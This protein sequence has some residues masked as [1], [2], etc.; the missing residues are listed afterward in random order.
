MAAAWED[1]SMRKL[2]G[3]SFLTAT[4]LASSA[5]AQG[6]F[7]DRGDPSAISATANG[8]YSTEF[9]GGGVGGGW[10]YRGVFDAG[11]DLTFLKLTAGTNKDLSRL[12]IAPFLT[13]H[14]LKAEPDEMPIS[15]SFVLSVIR[16]VYFGNDPV[17]NPEGWTGVLGVSLYRRFELGSSLVFVP[18]VFAAPQ[19]GATRYYSGALDQVSGNR[20][21]EI[22]YKSEAKWGARG[23]VRANLLI[24]AGNTKYL[25]MPYAGYV[26]AP[27]AGLQVGAMF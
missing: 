22:N 6:I 3:L 9:M 26:D 21:N 23:V 13:W 16:Q 12:A 14:A 15:L 7:I 4:L 2:I 19:Y 8:V 10:S 18:E 24:K 25:V 17:A 1:S 11:G 20:T 5:Q 27:G